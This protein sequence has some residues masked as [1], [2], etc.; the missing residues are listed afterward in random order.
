LGIGLD[1]Q[2]ALATNKLQGTC[3]S[4]SAAW[5][6]ARAGTVEVGDCLRGAAFSLAGAVIGAVTVQRLDPSFLRRF[7]PWLLLAVA[8]Y[9][10]LRPQLGGQDRQPELR[11]G[12]FDLVFGLGLGFYDGFFGPGVGTFW[13]VAFV[14]GLGFNLTR[15]TG[16][17]KV[18]NL[19]SN[20]GSLALFVWSGNVMYTAGVAMG[21]G[22]LVGARFG[23]H[24]VIRRGTQ[25][26]RPI[27]ISVV[28][29][30]TVKLLYDAYLR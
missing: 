26:I 23:A 11:R 27:F 22:Q 4:G 29:V 12:W 16:Y 20:L 13:A 3:G 5:H 15:A 30:L 9:A 25:F 2:H 19:A 7:I 14:M 17:T 21:V 28:L 10:L 8:I 1:P 24:M 6:Y 18:M